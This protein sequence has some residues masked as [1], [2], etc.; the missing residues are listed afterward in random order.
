MI[1]LFHIPYLLPRPLS[2]W[3]CPPH[4]LSPHQT[5]LLPGT[6]SLLRVWC[7]FSNWTQTW[8]S[9][10][11]YGVG[12]LI[13]AGIWCLFCGPVFERSRGSGLFETAG[14]PTRSPSSSASSSFSLIQP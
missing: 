14:P 4:H 10:A 11:V 8:Q 5:S 6:S 1:L 3:G 9:S 12:G 2:P 13:S 7:I